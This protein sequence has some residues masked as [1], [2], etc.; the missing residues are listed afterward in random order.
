MKYE[1]NLTGLCDYIRSM[2][3][4]RLRHVDAIVSNSRY[5]LNYLVLESNE[6]TLEKK[7]KLSDMLTQD[8]SVVGYMGV[9]IDVQTLEQKISWSKVNKYYEGDKYGKSS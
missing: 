7:K 2:L 4:D 5:Y 3:P 8:I 1:G 6:L 9:Y